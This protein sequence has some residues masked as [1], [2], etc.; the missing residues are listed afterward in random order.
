MCFARVSTSDQGALQ[1]W[2]N[3]LFHN[4]QFQLFERESK[5]TCQ[6]TVD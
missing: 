5:V 2:N 3:V 6:S 4:G 1:A